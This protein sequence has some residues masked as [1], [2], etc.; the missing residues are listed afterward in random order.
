MQNGERRSR[1]SQRCAHL[2][3]RR[4]EAS[5][6][7]VNGGG[8]ARAARS[9]AGFGGGVWLCAGGGARS[10]EGL[11][12]ALLWGRATMPAV[13]RTPRR[14]GGALAILAMTGLGKWPDGL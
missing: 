2:R 9:P 14:G 13:A 10:R 12:S 3:L 8:G 7:E 1:G 11:G 4:R 5:D 6:F